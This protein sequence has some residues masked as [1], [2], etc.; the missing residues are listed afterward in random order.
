MTQEVTNVEAEVAAR[1]EVLRRFIVE[2]VAKAA[3]EQDEFRDAVS[4][5]RTAAEARYHADLLRERE[6]HGRAR[7]ALAT[8]ADS[9]VTQTC[10]LALQVRENELMR[11]RMLKGHEIGILCASG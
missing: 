11:D 3:L 6:T 2:A 10:D 9:N 4:R 1:S 7:D 8:N 5:A